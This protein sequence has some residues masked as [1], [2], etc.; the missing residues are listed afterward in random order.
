MNGVT[1]FGKTKFCFFVV[2]SS[3]IHSVSKVNYVVGYFSPF[4]LPRFHSISFNR[5]DK[6]KDIEK[7]KLR[8]K[9][10]RGRDLVCSNFCYSP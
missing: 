2:T 6:K 4:L 9:E 1:R 7:V 5:I 3:N 8:K 10:T